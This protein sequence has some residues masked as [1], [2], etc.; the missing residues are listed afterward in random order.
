M[1]DLHALRTLTERAPDAHG[2]IMEGDW[3]WAWSYDPGLLIVAGLVT[4]CYLRGLLR[5]PE[6]DAEH[7]WWRTALFLSGI[8]VLVLAIESPLGR[9]GA[10]HFTLH[11]IQVQLLTAV[12]VPLVLLGAPSVPL[13]HGLP[14]WMR[15][16]VVRPLGR[17]EAAR[18]AW[19]GATHPAVGIT[20]LS[21]A[22]W[23]W[24][25]APGWH[26]RALMEATA[27]QLQYVSFIL[28]ALLF[29]WPVI[30]PHPLRSRIP[31]AGRIGYLVA[32]AVPRDMLAISIIF[33]ERQI[34]PLYIAT[35]PIFP[36]TPSD[37]QTYGG[38]VMWLGGDALYL[39]AAAVI[40]LVWRRRPRRTEAF[41]A[42][43]AVYGG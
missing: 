32:G 12:A 4:A 25:L 29:W 36:I 1:A 42:A 21:A 26:E 30:D 40:A 31:H 41:E 15:E 22:L 38:L 17:S 28:A 39:V 16:R 20:A 10:H 37:D 43:E 7:P 8:A 6:R 14:E 11:A 23:A 2:A 34:W 33:S 24:H 35:M 27:H 5:W 18:R 13:G 3:W 19:A 9:L